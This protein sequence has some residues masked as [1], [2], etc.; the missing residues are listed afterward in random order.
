MKYEKSN[1]LPILKLIFDKK[2]LLLFFIKIENKHKSFLVE[3]YCFFDVQQIQIFIITFFNK[4][5]NSST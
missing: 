2:L 3:W 5:I 4:L 1:V